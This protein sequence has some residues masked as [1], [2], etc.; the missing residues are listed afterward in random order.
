LIEVAKAEGWGQVP[1][2]TTRTLMAHTLDLDSPDSVERLAD[3][4]MV[5]GFV[6]RER[7]AEEYSR[8]LARAIIERLREES[9]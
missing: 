3:A 6:K 7:R 8:A 1:D 9:A 5:H 4:L 2:G